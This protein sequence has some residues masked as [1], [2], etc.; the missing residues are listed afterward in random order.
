[1]QAAEEGRPITLIVDDEPGIRNFVQHVAEAVGLQA[2]GAASG[3][4]ALELLKTVT[5]SIIVMDMQMPNGDGIQLI[6]GL[7]GLGIKA[8]IVILSG[9]D[10][11]L[12][13]VSASIARQRGLD[14]GA[15]LSKP[16]RFEELCKTLAALYGASMPFSA[17][18]LKAVIAD[19]IPILH[20]Q[21]KI[22]LVDASFVGV[23]ALLRCRDAADRSVSPELVIEIAERSG[24]ATELNHRIF[25]QAIAQR[26][27][28]SDA[29]K[30]LDVAINL[31]AAGSFDRELPDRLAA[32]CSEHKVPNHAITLEMTESSVENDKLVAMETMARLRLLGFR[33]SIDDFGTGHSSLVRLRHMPFTELKIDKSFVINLRGSNDNAVIVR[34]LA[35]LAQNLEMRCVIEGVEDAEALQFARG[36]GC[37]EAQGYHIARPMP[38]A[39][40]REF[41]L[42]WRW[43]RGTMGGAGEPGGDPQRNGTTRSRETAERG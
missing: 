41:E 39:E 40:I 37:D 21:P 1:M 19:D 27:A 32:L 10:N 30:E 6:Q 29:G 11:R 5:P 16:I 2:V 13:E 9:T 17:E 25:R 38:A 7:A 26:R 4:A 15:V 22:R 20:Y 24:L 42:T 31:S 23:E 34:S 14:I 3:G 36:L 12:L 35:Q 8:K 18:T 28:W 43:R 33:L